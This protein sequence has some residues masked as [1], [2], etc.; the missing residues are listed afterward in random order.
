MYPAHHGI[1][2]NNFQDPFSK[3]NY[4]MSDTNTVRDGRWYLG[5]AFWETAERQGI[6]SA[7]YFWPGSELL[8]PYRKPTYNQAYDH[9]RPYEKRVEGVIDWL[10]LPY[11]KR[12]HFITLYFHETDSKGHSSGP[13][14]PQTNEAIEKLDRIS[15]YLME[16]LAEINM[17]DSVN[18]I[19]LSDHGMTEV[20]KEK[21]I[22][23]EKI[24]G[25]IKCR[26]FDSGPLMFIEP[27]KENLKT[28]YDLLKKNENHYKVYYREEIPEFYHY[29]DHPFISSLVVIADMGWSAVNS[30]RPDW[31]GKGNH[32]YDN[33]HTDMHGIFLATGPDFKKNYR[34]GT[35]FNIDIYPLLCKLF[36][37]VP[38]ANIDGEADRIEFILNH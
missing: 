26:F 31:D 29:N 8:L 21:T 7:S 3:G 12:P 28:V 35:L 2:A 34:T 13:D 23:I 38:R 6:I 27:E 30:R 33:N 36:N 37:I 22:N 16:K 4:R 24:V 9:G 20:S 1:I 5:E 11:E 17:S 32:G 15:G 25:E 14:S 19:F 18:V 10:K